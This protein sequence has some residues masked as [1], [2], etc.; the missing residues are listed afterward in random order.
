[1]IISLKR[2]KHPKERKPRSRRRKVMTTRI[3][4]K[5][6]KSLLRLQRRKS[7]LKIYQNL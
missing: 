1:M 3:V 5:K 7:Q 6:M 4:K 2:L